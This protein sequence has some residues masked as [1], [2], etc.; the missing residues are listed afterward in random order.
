MPNRS[1]R[2]RHLRL[3]P[4]IQTESDVPPQR[5]DAVGV[6]PDKASPAIMQL[7]LYVSLVGVEPIVWRKIRVRSDL[8]LPEFHTVLQ[9]ALG[10]GGGTEYMMSGPVAGSLHTYCTQAMFGMTDDGMYGDHVR[11]DSMLLRR[12][13]FVRYQYGELWTHAIEVESTD[14]DIDDLRPSCLD[15]FGVCPP[16]EGYSPDTAHLQKAVHLRNLTEPV[17]KTIADANAR[18]RGSW[19]SRTPEVESTAA[20]PLVARIF[21]RVGNAAVP[22]L[23]ELLP[24]C[25]LTIES[26]V[27]LAVAQVA[28]TKVSWFLGRVGDRGMHLTDDGRLPPAAVEAMRDELDWGIGWVGD[29]ARESDHHQATD[30]REAAKALG[31]VRVLEGSLVRTKAGNLLVDDHIALWHHCASRLPLGRQDY[32]QDAG[33][34]FLVALAASASAAQRDV[35]VVETM[36]A[37]EWGV[38]AADASEAQK[39]ETQK[40][41]AQNAAHPTVAFLDLVG[42]HGPLFYLGSSGSDSPSWARRFARDA[43][44][45]GR[46]L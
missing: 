36:R 44:R 24:R 11:I 8:L 37:L 33:T 34:L 18:L 9:A 15:G 2:A 13:D 35:L 6:S 23:R 3:V 39:F 42:A 38:D 19:R 43:L 32:E 5:F 25:E 26:S 46:S 20:S 22:C 7:T 10:W 40:F 41:E 16:D 28:M 17:A 14:S 45:A 29:S 12:G 30:L 31:L 1:G 27:D 21:R 4:D